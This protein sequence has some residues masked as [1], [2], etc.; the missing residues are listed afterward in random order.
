LVDDN[1]T[2]VLECLIDGSLLDASLNYDLSATLRDD[3]NEIG[4]ET[5][6]SVLIE[7]ELNEVIIIE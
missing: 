7:T 2:V 5:E 1:S 3:T 6:L 4:I